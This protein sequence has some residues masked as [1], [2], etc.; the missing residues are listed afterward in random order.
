MLP[1]HPTPRADARSHRVLPWGSPI[2]AGI[3]VLARVH[4]DF[5]LLHPIIH[6]TIRLTTGQLLVAIIIEIGA[7]TGLRAY[8][9]G[10]AIAAAQRVASQK[11][12]SVARVESP[13]SATGQETRPGTGRPPRDDVVC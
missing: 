9:G 6:G 7:G 5:G 1:A 4:L 8:L 10:M 13:G 2:R 11:N 3:S 12:G